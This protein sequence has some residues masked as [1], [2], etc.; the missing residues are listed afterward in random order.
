[1]VREP[2]KFRPTLSQRAT[3]R[4]KEGRRERERE[5][6][7]GWGDRTGEEQESSNTFSSEILKPLH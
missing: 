6:G 7:V 3:E 1:M 5:G 4:G 2:A